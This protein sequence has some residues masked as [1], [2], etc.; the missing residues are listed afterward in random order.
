MTFPRPVIEHLSRNRILKR[1]LPVDLNHAPILVSP[2]ACLAHWKTRINSDLFDYAR[3]FVKPGSVIWDIGANVGLFTI[4]AAQKSGVKGQVVAVEADIWLAEVLRKSAALQP[5][6][7]APIQVVPAA[8]FSSMGLAEFHIARRGRAS[9]HLSDTRGSSQT[10]GIRDKVCVVTLTLDWL[11]QQGAA[12][13][14]IKIDVEGAEWN[15]LQGAIRV[16]SEAR[17]VL[18]C[19]VSEHV[20]EI[21]RLLLEHG[22][23]LFDWESNPRKMVT[24]ASFNTLAIPG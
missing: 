5:A 21:T 11:L 22:Y 7:S 3:E 13:S 1:R 18:L 23:S 6:D 15:V 4:A 19:E 20:P 24:T 2:D 9:N 12:P 8:A 14:V 17:P 16:L 10:G